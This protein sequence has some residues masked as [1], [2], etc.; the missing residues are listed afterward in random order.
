MFSAV[1]FD[2]LIAAAEQND[3]S[4]RPG[5]VAK[6]RWTR[7]KILSTLQDRH[8]AGLRLDFTAVNRG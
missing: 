7:A 6:T 2:A 5:T 4:V 8:G 1:T 3:C